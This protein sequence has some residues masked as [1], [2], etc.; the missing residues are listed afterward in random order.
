VHK[1]LFRLIEDTAE[2]K[3][4]PVQREVAS[5]GTGTDTDSFAYAAGGV[6]AA[7]IS[8]PLRYMHTTVESAHKEDVEAVIRLIYE[9]LLALKPDRDQFRYL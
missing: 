9:T 7:L 3:K 1:T 5:R 6:P 8:L 2:R 4:I